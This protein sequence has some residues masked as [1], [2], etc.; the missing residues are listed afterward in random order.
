M[1]QRLTDRLILT[2]PAPAKGNKPYWDAPNRGGGDFTPG[3]GLCV[4]AGGARSFILNYRTNSG[5]QRRLVI[6][7]P[8]AWSLSAARKEAGEL[9]RRID[10]GVDPQA[11]KEADR[12]APNMRD[13]CER[14]K[15]EFL[16][17]KRPSTAKDY[18]ALIDNHILPALGAMKVTDVAFVDADRLHRSMSGTP[19]WAN[20]CATMG[21]KLFNLAIRWRLRVDNPFKGIE[22]FPEEKR[23]T[24]LSEAQLPALVSALAAHSD[25]QMSNVFRL[26]LLTGARRGEALAAK[27]DQFD[28][29]T[30]VWT[31]SAASTKQ[32]KMHRTP[33]SAAA[34]ELLRQIRS[35][36]DT[37]SPWVFPNG[38]GHLVD[39]KKS[40]ASICRAA[41]ISGLRIH[42]LR[43]TYASMLVNAGLSLPT[44]GAMLGHTQVSTT[45]RYSHL[46]DS[47]LRTAAE[48]VGQLITSAKQRAGVVVDLGAERIK[49]QS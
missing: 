33:L 22:R 25:Q 24:Y 37:T 6:G 34:V 32:A 49:A 35:E 30:G 43:H 41:G 3:F 47:T 1:R 42:D 12:E 40:W 31:K 17:S 5:R 23:A 20:R 48:H 27:W 13:L 29:E 14:V 21:L 38:D 15:N 16:P 11:E 39:P 19:Y 8:P 2:L 18:R 36:S 26:L 45:A 10:G 4:T 7:S 44:I 9:R 28:L 46:V